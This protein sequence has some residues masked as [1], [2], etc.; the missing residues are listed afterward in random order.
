MFRV[1]CKT[2]WAAPG[3][4]E[5]AGLCCRGI[6]RAPD[7]RP[8][9]WEFAVGEFQPPTPPSG[10]FFSRLS[11]YVKVGVMFFNHKPHVTFGLRDFLWLKP[12]G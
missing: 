10:E 3:D 7:V 2:T 6:V 12:L 11:F 9:D 5:N 1:V 4:T 8:E